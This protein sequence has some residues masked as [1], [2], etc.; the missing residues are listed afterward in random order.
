M[1]Q[2]YPKKTRMC[3]GICV[4]LLILIFISQLLPY[5]QIDGQ[6][7]AIFPYCWDP[8]A[9]TDLGNYLKQEIP[10]YRFFNL[11]LLPTL[12]FWL[13]LPSAIVTVIFQKKVYALAG[14]IVCGLMGTVSYLTN[15][16]LKLGSGWI[17]HLLLCIL[18]LA[19]SL[20]AVFFQKKDKVAA[21]K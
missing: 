11:F 9:D 7:K 20:A 6:E 14:A 10:D 1:E 21:E 16:A 4:L 12:L 17:V 3:R 2:V 18:L 15:P 8:H 13:S 5:W 19:A